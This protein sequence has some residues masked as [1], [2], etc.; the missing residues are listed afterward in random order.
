MLD[1]V[2]YLAT[3]LEER[4]ASAVVEGETLEDRLWEVL[5]ALS[6]HYEQDDYLVQM[7]ILLDL[8]ANPRFSTA[9]RRAQ[10]RKNGEVFDTLAQ[11][12]FARALREVA[13]E[14]DLVFFA[15]KA[16]RSYVSWSAVSRRMAEF[17][18]DVLPR[19][20]DNSTDEGVLRGLF[21]RSV[22]TTIREEARRRGYRVS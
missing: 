10:R 21:V 9:N 13:T 19:L 14:R 15:Y 20:I 3:R 6:S 8:S 7:Q 22:A 11:P 4:L 5:G 16:F 2:N 1:V 18:K 12:L 17:P